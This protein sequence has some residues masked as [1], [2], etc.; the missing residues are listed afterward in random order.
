MPGLLPT[1]AAL[2]LGLHAAAGLRYRQ[3]LAGPPRS[4]PAA[5]PR[6]QWFPQRLDHFRP[7]ESRTWKQRY[8]ISWE[9]YRPGGPAL[10]MIG[11]EGEANPAWLGAGAWT[12]Y[13]ARCVII[14]NNRE[15]L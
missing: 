1:A 5:P 14:T 7:T 3:G 11:G 8:W 6:P 10:L 2:L 15:R 9:H 12:G 13:A 4:D